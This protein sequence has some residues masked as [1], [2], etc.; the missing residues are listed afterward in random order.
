M[1]ACISEMIFKVIGGLGIFL[2]GMSNLTNGL[3]TV[4]GDRLRWLIGKIT[5]N[6]FLAA[7]VGVI[8]TTIV[9][10]SS[11]TTVMV[12]GF[13]NS[14]L[15]TLTQ[16]IG[17][18]M[19]ANIGTTIT[20]WIIAVKIGKYGLPMLGIAALIMLFCKRDKLKYIAMAIM[21]LG[22]VFFGLE[23]MANGFKPIRAIPEF[24][25]WFE[26]F[27][28]TT[29]LGMLQCIG[30]GAILTM[31]VQS[32][33]ATL[34]ITMALATTGVIG[35]ETAAALVLGENIGTT[36]TAF[37]A[38]IGAK[39]N[40]RRAAYAHVIFNIAGVLWISLLFPVY[41]Q[42]IEQITGYL[43][44]NPSVEFKIASVHTGFNVV[45][46]ILFLTLVPY[47]AKFLEK[48]VPDPKFEE[49]SKITK[50]D[51]RIL[52]T[53]QIALEQSKL[54][55][56]NIF[57]MLKQMLKDINTSIQNNETKDSKIVQDVFKT[58]ELIDIMQKE[59]TEYI[60]VLMSAGMT[61]SESLESKN[62]LRIVD[63]LETISDYIKDIL[64]TYLA[65]TDKGITF[66]KSALSEMKT[67]HIKVGEYILSVCEAYKSD[68]RGIIATAVPDGDAIKFLYKDIRNT[69][70]DRLAAGETNPV[71]TIAFIDIL[72]SYRRIKDHLLNVAEETSSKPL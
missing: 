64:K 68:N 15:M 2:L 1:E 31:I 35:F 32:S 13:V 24:R 70:L 39:T 69:H 50:L 60:T 71:K 27:Q 59:I 49:I 21:G 37:L 52:E 5:G 38:S 9:Q 28:A 29:Y 3:Q 41:I 56:I 16:A 22:M 20:G 55:I 34:G 47:L 8:V 46:T 25:Q 11:I 72:N 48:I 66:G 7:F 65:L 6:R 45:N 14:S 62:Q 36:I 67:L 40:A 26:M 17:V 42:L 33:S 4:A 18:I 61:N 30:I 44:A 57:R 10:S 51:A 58:E 12:V 43:S 54:E 23:L 63:E 19:G 53:P